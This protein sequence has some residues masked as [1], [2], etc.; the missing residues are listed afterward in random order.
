MHDTQLSFVRVRLPF[1][2]AQLNAQINQGPENAIQPIDQ[3]MLD[4]V[5][6]FVCQC[7]FGAAI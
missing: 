5:R 6:R 1:I 7:C 3:A 2:N 4:H